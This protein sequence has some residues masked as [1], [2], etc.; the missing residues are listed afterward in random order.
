MC[1]YVVN[2]FPLLKIRQNQEN[3][4]MA[5]TEIQWFNPRRK[6]EMEN[7]NLVRSGL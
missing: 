4:K 7:E 3:E 2:A 6:K 5:L 1:T